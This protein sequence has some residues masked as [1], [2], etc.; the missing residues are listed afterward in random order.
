[1]SCGGARESS[2]S[3]GLCAEM[4][5]TSGTK[6][7]PRQIP[8]LLGAGGMSEVYSVRDTRLDR[9]PKYH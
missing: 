7:G 1:M 2:V 8:S 5:L 4:A 3:Q 9:S 6:L